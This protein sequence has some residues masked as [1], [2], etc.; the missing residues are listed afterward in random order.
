LAVALAAVIIGWFTAGESAHRRAVAEADRIDPGWRWEELQAKRAVVPDE[1]N[2]ALVIL[3]LKDRWP[4][5]MI[6]GELHEFHVGLTMGL[7]PEV[8]PT[9]V[10]LDYLREVVV[11]AGPPLTEARRLARY[12]RGRFPVDWPEKSCTAFG[13]SSEAVTTAS[14][15]QYDAID[16]IEAGDI[17]GAWTAVRA[18]FACSLAIGDDPSGQSQSY[19]KSCRAMALL[20]L[21][22]LLAQLQPPADL[23]ADVQARLEADEPADLWLFAARGL[24]AESDRYWGWFDRNLPLKQRLLMLIQDREWTAARNRAPGLRWLTA[25][26]EALKSPDAEREVRT[27]ELVEASAALPL[28]VAGTAKNVESFGRGYRRSHAQMRCAIAALAAERFRL[29][30]GRW[31]A[32]LE[33]LVT[34]GLLRAVPLDPYDRKPLRCKAVADG[35]I[36]YTIGIDETDNGGNLHRHDETPPGY[37]LGFRLWDPAARRPPPPAT[38]GGRP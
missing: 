34:A 20:A 23:L 28:F 18:A 5:Y 2:A 36:V 22:R 19:R 27:A 12:D 38:P 33:E 4:T 9:A 24:R 14:W 32:S 15:L 17:P 29:A 13:R 21:E 30:R 6:S 1:E 8:R 10:Q 7:S 26:I 35:L 16:R 31:P 25:F 37:D 3:C 11:K